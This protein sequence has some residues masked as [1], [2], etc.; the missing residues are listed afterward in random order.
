MKVVVVVV[1]GG[2]E[3]IVSID[4]S[5]NIDQFRYFHKSIDFNTKFKLNTIDYILY[6]SFLY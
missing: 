3:V 1:V 6:L 5:R 2:G 4:K